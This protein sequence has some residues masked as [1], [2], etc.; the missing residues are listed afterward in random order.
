MGA[1][2]L[3]RARQPGYEEPLPDEVAD[4]LPPDPLEA[5]AVP[6]VMEDEAPV[7]MAAAEPVMEGAPELTPEEVDAEVMGWQAENERAEQ[8]LDAGLEAAA[9]EIAPDPDPVAPP[10]DLRMRQLLYQ[11]RNQMRKE[12]NGRTTPPSAAAL[13]GW[14]AVAYPERF[15]GTTEDEI[16]EVDR[17]I[18]G[19]ARAARERQMAARFA[20]GQPG[21]WW[22]RNQA[23]Q[24]M[25]QQFM[26]MD[27]ENQQAMMLEMN[28]APDIEQVW[29]PRT[30]SFQYKVTRRG[31][32]P[33][34]ARTLARANQ[35]D[36]DAQD[37]DRQS[38]ENMAKLNADTQMGVENVR[39]GV[40]DR[41]MSQADRAAS[42]KLKFEREKLTADIGKAEAE[43]KQALAMGNARLAQ[44]K[45]LAIEGL[46]RRDR[47]L[48]DAEERTRVTAEG[49]AA[50]R[51]PTPAEAARSMGDAEAAGLEREV[52]ARAGELR[53]NRY[54]RARAYG[55]LRADPKFRVLRPKEIQSALNAAGFPPQ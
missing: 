54:T 28:T 20:A 37:A 35:A 19:D 32:T 2:A 49:A 38:R 44:E 50:Q 43:M 23:G 29:N 26:D 53:K 17:L 41:Q 10:G 46:K 52:E 55:A 51:P 7:E 30:N 13:A 18:Q 14:L 39:A 42:E 1:Q 25:A 40:A 16:A 27:P 34:D 12:R 11:A 48:D 4:D 8:E 33:N 15:A 24:L 21:P 31:Q 47:E 5:A 45:F 9:A 3:Y 22:A 6:M 36:R